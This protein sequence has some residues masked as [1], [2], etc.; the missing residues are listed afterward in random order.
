MVG[1]GEMIRHRPIALYLSPH[2]PFHL[3]LIRLPQL[4]FTSPLA[5]TPPSLS[6]SFLLSCP[7]PRTS[8]SAATPL[9]TALQSRRVELSALPGNNPR[10][11]FSPLSSTLTTLS[12]GCQPQHSTSCSPCIPTSRYKTSRSSPTRSLPTPTLLL[13]QNMPMLWSG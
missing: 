7:P 9:T 11:R 10:P 2:L 8:S 6:P 1:I 4:S 12:S 5:F 3:P 13:E